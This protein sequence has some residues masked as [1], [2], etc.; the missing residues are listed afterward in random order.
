MAAKLSAGVLLFRRRDGEVEVLLG[1][2][3]GPF[4]AKKDH[5]AWSIPKGELDADEDPFAGAIREFEE[6]T[7]YRPSGDFIPLTPIT[8]SGGK[9]VLAWA[10]EGDLDPTSVRSN[11]F[12]L[13][14]PP[15]SGRVVE[16]PEIDRAEWFSIAEARARLLPGQV[17]FL[18][19][20]AEKA[21]TAGPDPAG[22]S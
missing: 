9:R 17:P 12:S 1:H 5:G 13:E 11:T 16:F 3:G 6:E 8:Q 21:R 7:G 4:W 10:V 18:D 19:D 22:G 14:W 15:R 2:P 20:L